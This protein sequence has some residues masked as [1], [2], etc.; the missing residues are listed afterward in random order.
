[1]TILSNGLSALIITI[2]SISLTMP[3]LAQS[4]GGLRGGP[5]EERAPVLNDIAKPGEPIVTLRYFKIRKGTFP[6]FLKASQTGVWP[7][8][9]KIGARVIGMW[10]VVGDAD[11]ARDGADY[12]EVYLMTEYASRAHWAATRQPWALGGNGPDFDALMEALQYRNS[13]TLETSVIMLQGD[14]GP[15][16]PYFLPGLTGTE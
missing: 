12:D 1:M 6:E 16:G 3:A 14:T 2:L 13:V 15:K 8:F 7:Y 10:Q 11:G 4:E 5:P 9:E